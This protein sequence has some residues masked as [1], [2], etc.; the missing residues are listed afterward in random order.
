MPQRK[1]N[2]KAKAPKKGAVSA[3]ASRPTVAICGVP[4]KTGKPCKQT[5]LTESGRCRRHEG[6]AAVP[7]VTVKALGPG[8]PLGNQNPRKHGLFSSVLGGIG[9]E[10]YDSAKGMEADA[11]GR[12][13]AEFL[14]AK[15]AE[16]YRSD[17]GWEEAKGIVRKLLKEAVDCEEIEP[18][19]ADALAAKLQM[20]DLATLGKALGPLKALLEVKRRKNT[21]GGTNALQNLAD[22]V[23]RSQTRR[24][25]EAKEG[26]TEG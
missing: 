8:A 5:I 3:S 17:Q 13:T 4:G 22:V 6:E 11:L 10:V 9:R 20:P 18:E 25:A 12:D 26:G 23:K 24:N 15:V 16:A 19:T 1:N 14:I 21:G 7:I 2:S